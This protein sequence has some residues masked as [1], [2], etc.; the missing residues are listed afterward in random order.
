MCIR[1]RIRALEQM[2]VQFACNAKLGEN[3]KISDLTAEYDKVFIA[4]GAWKRPVLGFDG[5]EFTEFGLQFLVDVNK[6]VNSKER[7]N[8]LVVGGGNVSM[9]VAITAKRL[10][11]KRVTLCCLEQREEMPASAEEIARAEELSLIH[12]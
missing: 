5:E 8:V 10:G 4:T 1:D 2:G 6:W 3:V 12:I 9:D 11:A 7:N